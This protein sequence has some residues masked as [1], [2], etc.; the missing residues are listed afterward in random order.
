V[1]WAIGF[2]HK[3]SKLFAKGTTTAAVSRE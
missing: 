1:D 3:A 2:W